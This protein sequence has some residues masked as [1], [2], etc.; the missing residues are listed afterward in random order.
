[1]FTDGDAGWVFPTRS[2]KAKRHFASPFGGD[3]HDSDAR[4]QMAGTIAN[5][6]STAT[7]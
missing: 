4:C 2:L 6:L 5:H 1:V 7:R 3:G